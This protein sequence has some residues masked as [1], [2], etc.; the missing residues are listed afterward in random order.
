MEMSPVCTNAKVVCIVASS[1]QDSDLQR[2]G[3]H[4]LDEGHCFTVQG[5][6]RPSAQRQVDQRKVRH[7]RG[8]VPQPSAML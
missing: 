6:W 5:C 8:I 3:D 4:S 2:N 7:V 1:S